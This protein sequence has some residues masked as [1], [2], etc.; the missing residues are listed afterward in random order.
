MKCNIKKSGIYIIKNN[1]NGK[2]YVGSTVNFY[3][4]IKKHRANL[5][6]DKHHSIKLQRACNKYGFE[7]LE[8]IIIEF[9]GK[10][11]L[12]ESEQFWINHFDSYHQGY[13]STPNAKNC[14]GYKQTEEHKKN[15][16]NGL[17]GYKRSEENIENMR[18]AN[19]GKILSEETKNKLSI[20]NTGKIHS[21]ETKNKLSIINKGKKHSED[22]KDKMRKFKSEEH[23]QNISKG[24]KGII[25]SEEHILNLKIARNNRKLKK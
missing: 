14:L 21:E 24:R 8:F 2:V 7:N 9:C 10:D 25:F 16:S 19:K 20:I 11:K 23:K 4:R 6:N 13:N 18:L 22:S 12:I 3:D 15:I 17:K 1:I 5:K